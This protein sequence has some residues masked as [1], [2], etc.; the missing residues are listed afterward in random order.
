MDQPTFSFHDLGR[1]LEFDIYLKGSLLVMNSSHLLA[2]LI[3]IRILCFKQYRIIVL[4]LQRKTSR[5]ASIYKPK[6]RWIL[7]FF[8]IIII[9]TSS[10]FWNDLW[11]IPFPNSENDSN[12]KVM[13]KAAINTSIYIL[14]FVSQNPLPHIKEHEIVKLWLTQIC[15]HTHTKCSA[16]TGR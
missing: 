11:T 5:A 4:I 6:A 9:I 12:A 14:H 15:S 3:V 7:L 10:A 8:V 16:L 13:Q 2:Y 1:K